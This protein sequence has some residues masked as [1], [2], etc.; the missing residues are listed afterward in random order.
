MK[1]TIVKIT[2]NYK[3]V[4]LFLL[5]AVIFVQAH[6]VK[7]Q[8]APVQNTNSESASTAAKR[9]LAKIDSRSFSKIKDARMRKA[10]EQSYKALK[11]VADNK[12]KSRE[13]RLIEAFDRTIKDLKTLPQPT[14]GGTQECDSGYDT[15]I[16][17]CKNTP[18]SDC[19]QCGWGQN[20]CYLVKLAIDEAQKNDPSKN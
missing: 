2:R 5:A 18:G 6:A 4:F 20:L 9:A 3:Q 15:C 13:D 7:A 10:L 19:K 1:Q 16:E 11:A 8:T 14:G 12:S 17:V